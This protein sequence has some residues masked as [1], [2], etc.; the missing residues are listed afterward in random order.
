M[1]APLARVCRR[2]TS[3]T[4]ATSAISQWRRG[5]AT[6][7]PPVTQD[8]AGSKGPTAMVFMNMGGPSTTSE[9]GDFL[10]RLFVCRYSQHAM[11]NQLTLLGRCRLDT[12]RATT[13]LH[14]PSHRS[15]KNAK[16]R[17]TIFRDWRRFAHPEM[18]RISSCRDVQDSRQDI[19]RN[20]AA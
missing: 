19:T 14:W 5:N 1:R 7:A 13:K 8:A 18:V 6:V 2:A 3:S 16:D 17:R 12:A 15:S 4:P 20:R 10:S 11:H 9:V